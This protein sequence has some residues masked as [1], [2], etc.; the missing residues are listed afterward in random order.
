M[1]RDSSIGG[2]SLA[3]GRSA[4]ITGVC[5]AVRLSVFPYAQTLDAT[6]TSPYIAF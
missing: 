6:K 1:I 4:V 3:G 5:T 2:S